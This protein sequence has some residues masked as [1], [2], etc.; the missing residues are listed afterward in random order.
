V[1]A[2]PAGFPYFEPQFLAS[3]DKLF[4]HLLE[5]I[6]WDERMKAR[7]TA[8][9]GDSY[10]Y[11]QIAYEQAPMPGERGTGPLAS[12]NSK[13]GRGRAAHQHD[14]QVNCQTGEMR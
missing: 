13:N 8:S 7:K 12:R 9:F 1:S 14:L 10:D 5:S 11:S 6:E 4:D 2:G 3:P